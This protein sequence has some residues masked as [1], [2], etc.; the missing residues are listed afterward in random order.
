MRLPIVLLPGHMCDARLFGPLI[1]DLRGELVL[2]GD[3]TA[4]LSVAAMAQRVLASA[5]P[6]FAL[7]GLSMGGIVAL[8]MA[9]QAPQRIARIALL[10]TNPLP[11]SEDRSTMR[12]ELMRLV[13]AGGLKSVVVER[14]KP[15]YLAAVN[16]DNAT[17]LALVVEMAIDLGAEVFE[18]QA[19]ALLSRPDGRTALGELRVPALVLCGREDALCTVAVHQAM[20][21][22][23]PGS[24]LVVVEQ[25]G[26]LPTL[27][28]P[29]AVNA[30]VRDWLN[31]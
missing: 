25:A 29:E 12:L 1:D 28:R 15:A 30:A 7:L 19:R 4:D 26:H 8:D 22:A 2:V 10:D 31:S 24:T 27:E 21:A 6:R 13:A 14:L 17:L 5:P 9:R 23:I 16:R 3:L 18:R 11:E 20:A